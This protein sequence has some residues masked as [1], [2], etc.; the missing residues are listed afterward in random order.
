MTLTKVRFLF[1]KRSDED[2]FFEEKVVAVKI[3]L[4]RLENA[5]KYIIDYLNPDNSEYLTASLN[6]ITTK[7][8][9]GVEFLYEKFDWHLTNNNF[10]QSHGINQ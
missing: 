4:R 7:V 1:D 10:Y 6:T 3:N 8:T 5:S 9:E 2:K